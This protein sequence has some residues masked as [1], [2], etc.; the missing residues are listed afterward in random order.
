MKKIRLILIV[1]A[2]I[3][4][5]A[6]SAQEKG[7]Q[8]TEQRATEQ[9]N[10]LKT[11]VG[12]AKLTEEQEKK[13]YGITLEKLNEIKQARKDIQDQQV[14]DEKIKEIQKKYGKKIFEEVLSKEQKA[15]VKEYEQKNKK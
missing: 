7:K 15:A 13:I 2:V 10:L 5:T 11:K 6:L 3:S 12:E 9:V 1:F 14:L 8:T 4:A